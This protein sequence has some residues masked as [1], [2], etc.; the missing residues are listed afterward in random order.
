MPKVR[1]SSGTIGTQRLPVS[2]SR[3]RSLTRRTN[4]MV[5]AISWLP[6]PFVERVERLGRRLGQGHRVH[7]AGRGGAAELGAALLEVAHLGGVRAGVDVR[8]ELVVQLAVRDGQ[9]QEVAHRAELL[10]GQ[11]LHL[12]VGVARLEAGAERPALDGLG[13][14]HGRRALVLDGRAVGRVHLAGLVAGAGG[15]EALGDL[16]VGEQLRHLGERRVGAEE[17]LADVGGVAGRVRLELGVRAPRAAGGP[18]RRWCPARTA[19]PRRSPTAT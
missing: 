7:L 5:V 13:E 11:L 8:H 9:L 15:V 17:V 3:I 6:E 1:A 18:A 10:A 12:V 14:D 2:L 19:R 4:A 16:V